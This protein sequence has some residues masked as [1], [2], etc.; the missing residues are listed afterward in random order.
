V[1]SRGRVRLRRVAN[2]PLAL[3]SSRLAL[4]EAEAFSPFL[5]GLNTGKIVGG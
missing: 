3:G 1:L 2:D 4:C 5:K